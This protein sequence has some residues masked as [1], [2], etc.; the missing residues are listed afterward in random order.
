MIVKLNSP[1]NKE[2]EKIWDY[3]GIPN[4]IEA[5]QWIGI[6]GTEICEF[7]RCPENGHIIKQ[8]SPGFIDGSHYPWAYTDIVFAQTYDVV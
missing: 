7:I 6:N 1:G 4:G 3:L 8:K 2:L 5:I